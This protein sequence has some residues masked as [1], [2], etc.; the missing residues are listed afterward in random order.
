MLKINVRQFNRKMYDFI[1]LL[2]IIVYNK[3]TGVE[4]FIVYPVI[5]KG[6]D[7]NDIVQSKQETS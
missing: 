7:V 3:K 4:L 5:K 2:P 6:S 1:D